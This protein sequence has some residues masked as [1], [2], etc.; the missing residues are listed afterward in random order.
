MLLYANRAAGP[1]LQFRVHGQLTVSDLQVGKI[2]T[3]KYFIFHPFSLPGCRQWTAYG[4]GLL[5]QYLRRQAGVDGGGG[6]T[7]GEDPVDGRYHR[8][9]A[10]NEKLFMLLGSDI[11]DY[12][13]LAVQITLCKSVISLRKITYHTAKIFR[14]FPHFYFMIFFMVLFPY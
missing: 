5:F 2:F 9:C 11:S 14:D 12:T 7:G 3:R 10:G 4:S 6:D 13:T 8:D 1:G